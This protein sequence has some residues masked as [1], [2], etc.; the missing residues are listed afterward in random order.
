MIFFNWHFVIPCQLGAQKLGL[1][2]I[3]T[4]NVACFTVTMSFITCALFCELAYLVW[5]FHFSH[6]LLHSS[7]VTYQVS[8]FCMSP[9]LSNHRT[10]PFLTLFYWNAFHLSFLY[11]LLWLGKKKLFPLK[12]ARISQV[13]ISRRLTYQFCGN[14][15]SCI[16][17]LLFSNS[18]FSPS[19][20]WQAHSFLIATP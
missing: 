14:L 6:L 17:L 19:E 20:E 9:Q 2:L 15:L 1:P 18:L 7:R 13:F 4:E 5:P 16:L 10:L 8:T 12:I 3:I 11:S